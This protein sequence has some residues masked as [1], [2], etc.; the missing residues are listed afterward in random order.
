[1]VRA[2][3]DVGGPRGGRR[4]TGRESSRTLPS[5]WDPGVRP[6][7]GRSISGYNPRALF[8]WDPEKAASNVAKHGVTFEEAQTVFQDDLF[9][10]FEDPDHSQGESRLIILGQSTT[11][12]RLLVVAYTERRKAIRL[13]SAREA[14]RKERR[15]YEE[16]S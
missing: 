2:G 4:G 7:E 10:A 9:V 6:G 11:R 16:E 1:M 14:T 8:E 3:E 5:P 13:I 15:A 12:S